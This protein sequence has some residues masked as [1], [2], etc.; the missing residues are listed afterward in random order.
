MLPGREIV[1]SSSKKAILFQ[2]CKRASMSPILRFALRSLARPAFAVLNASLDVSVGKSA[3]PQFSEISTTRALSAGEHG[4]RA[5]ALPS[6]IETL[7]RD[8]HVH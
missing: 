1:M 8:C 7:R 5:V 2:P 4:T 6:E 3:W